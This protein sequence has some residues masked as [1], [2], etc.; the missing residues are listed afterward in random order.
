MTHDNFSKT[1]FSLLALAFGAV[2][3]TA[4]AFSY[5]ERD[6][7]PDETIRQVTPNSITTE[8]IAYCGQQDLKAACRPMFYRNSDGH[9]FAVVNSPALVSALGDGAQNLRVNLS[10]DVIL[11]A[12]FASDRLRVTEFSVLQYLKGGIRDVAG[13]VG[14]AQTDDDQTSHDHG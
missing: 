1:G 8:G 3:Y 5:M 10:G 4:P 11:S 13:K 7:Y 6:G 2:L 9:I 14:P 12:L